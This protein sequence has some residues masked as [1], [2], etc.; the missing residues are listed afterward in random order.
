MAWSVV[1]AIA[2]S[3]MS[4][5]ATSE[6]FSCCPGQENYRLAISSPACCGEGCGDRLAAGQERPCV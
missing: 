4:G 3:L 6:C 5:F 2:V 1:G